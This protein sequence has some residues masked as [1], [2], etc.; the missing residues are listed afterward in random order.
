MAQSCV[1]RPCVKNSKGDIVESRLFNDLLSY[2][3]S[4]SEATKYYNLARNK[5]FLT[6]IEG[7]VKFDENG[8]ITIEDLIREAHISIDKSKLQQSLQ[9]EVGTQVRDYQ[10]SIRRVISF[11]KNHSFRESYMAILEETEGKFT[12]KIVENTLENLEALKKTIE[13]QEL[14][15]RLI[16]RLAEAGVDVSFI[17]E[18]YSRYNTINATQNA[19]GLYQSIEFYKYGTTPEL[20]EEAGH[21]VVGAMTGTPLMDRLEKLLTP[22]VQKEV[23]GEELNT[24]FLGHNPKRE[25]AGILVGRQL[26]TDVE[27]TSTNPVA[28]SFGL[29]VLVVQA[30]VLYKADFGTP[31]AIHAAVTALEQSH[32]HFFIILDASQFTSSAYLIKVFL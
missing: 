20:A 1:I 32:S 24:R 31:A 7:N 13:G 8:E 25:V 4:R 11:N 26:A 28:T 22:Q 2:L 10:D 17:E 3:P 29:K 14:K 30:F 18:N 15:N 21:F 12:V 5:E 23:L 27:N 19:N 9:D 6:Q 16:F